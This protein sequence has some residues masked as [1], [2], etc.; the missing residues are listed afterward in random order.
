MRAG[1]GALVACL[2]ALAVFV[3]SDAR[4]EARVLLIRPEGGTAI[5][6]DAVQSFRYAI[7]RSAPD[8][9]FVRTIAEASD[10]IEFTGYDWAFDENLGVTQTWQFSVRRLATPEDPASGR[11]LPANLVLTVPG[12]TLAESTQV[13]I[14][15]LRERLHRLLTK[16]EPNA[17]K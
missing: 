8:V 1:K 16:L 7:L 17:A 11:A 2:C 6:R 4:C 3:A 14:E 5:P 12:K 10:L 9:R 13:S 15:M